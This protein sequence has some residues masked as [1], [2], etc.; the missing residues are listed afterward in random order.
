[1]RA[2]VVMSQA[3][4]QGVFMRS[5]TAPA[6]NRSGPVQAHGQIKKVI[7]KALKHFVVGR[8]TIG[9]DKVVGEPQ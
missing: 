1:M 7:P 3:I 2:N 4:T 6:I 8:D 9:E 5:A